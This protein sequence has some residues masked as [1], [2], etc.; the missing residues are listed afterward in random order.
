MEAVIDGRLGPPWGG[1]VCVVAMDEA[2]D[3]GEMDVTRAAG[4]TRSARDEVSSASPIDAQ[5]SCDRST[6]IANKVLSKQAWNV[7]LSRFVKRSSPK[8][9]FINL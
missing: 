7:L 5:H 4:N 9:N 8:S 3:Y 1:V 2:G 6:C